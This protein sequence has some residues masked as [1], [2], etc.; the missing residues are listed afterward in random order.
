MRCG[1]MIALALLGA[2]S[3]FAPA[4][5]LAGGPESN[6]SSAKVDGPAATI[7]LASQVGDCTARWDGEPLSHE[8]I[9]ERGLELL[10]NRVEAVGGP[11]FVTQED[12]PYLRVEAPAA[13]P[14]PC[15]GRVLGSLQHSGFAE[16]LLRPTDGRRTPDQRLHLPLDV[17]AAARPDRL[18]AVGAGGA[19]RENGELHDRA[20]LRDF[21]R[22][23]TAGTPDDFF[24]A[25]TAEASF[26]DVYQTLIDLN[27]GGA[28]VMLAAGPAAPGEAADPPTANL[29]R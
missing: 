16:A 5:E 17:E 10:V 20:A 11:E 2:C 27:A 7:T 26:G 25:P 4:N 1:P 24:I 18:V 13:M 6:V 28:G 8:A 29:S 22:S 19:I 15:A 14:W 21:A 12:M 3:K 9:G 23:Y